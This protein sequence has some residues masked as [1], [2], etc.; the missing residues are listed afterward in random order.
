MIEAGS[1]PNRDEPMTMRRLLDIASDPLVTQP[2]DRIG[3]PDLVTRFGGLG[4]GLVDLLTERNGFYAFES[5]LLVRPLGKSSSPLDLASW[6]SE[7]LWV[8]RYAL[9]NLPT[10]LF[11]AEDLFGN[12]FAISDSGVVSFDPETGELAPLADSLQS[13]CDVLLSDFNAHTGYPVAHEWQA[14][15]GPLEPGYR[16][17]PKVPFVAGGAFRVDN[18]LAMNEAEGMAYR[19]DFA[20]Q[21]RD[22]PDGAEIRI[23]FD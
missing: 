12:Q 4:A 16:L 10:L 1:A 13:W 6:N 22:L 11:F 2:I 21:I 17:I 3:A 19:A 5:A 9:F 23:R 20:N 14:K 18:L 15:H 7:T 8:S